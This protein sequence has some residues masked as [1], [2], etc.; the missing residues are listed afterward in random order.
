MLLTKPAIDS[1]SSGL[2][3]VTRAS[4]R[5]NASDSSSEVLNG[6]KKN[7]SVQPSVV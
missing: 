4:S 2:V 6:E 7:E 3:H 5:R 1:A